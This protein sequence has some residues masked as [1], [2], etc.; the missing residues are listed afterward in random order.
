M[1]GRRLLDAARLFSA[2]SSIVKQHFA[3]RS[4]QW[5]VYTRTSTLAR[6]VKD[7]TDRVTV[8]ARAAYA[9]ARRVNEKPPSY[10]SSSTA[11]Y[12]TQ[13]RYE[14]ESIPGQENVAVGERGKQ[15]YEQGLN[16]DHHYKRS[17]ENAAVEDPPNQ[18]LKVRQEP[19][20]RNALP[21]GTIP[22][23][24]AKLEGASGSQ[25][26]DTFNRRPVSEPAQE[27]LVERSDLG[28]TQKKA[29][30]SPLPDGTIPP[31][32]ARFDKDPA[33]G[34]GEVYSDRPVPETAA[35]PLATN[36]EKTGD[37]LQPVESGESSIP[38][39]RS[40]KD[41][42]K[43]QRLSEFQIPSQSGSEEKSPTAGQDTF[44]DRPCA[45]S[46]D[47]SSLPRMKIPKSEADI[48]GGDEHVQDGQLNQDVYYSS[49]RQPRQPPIPAT[50]AVLEQDEMAEGINT[51]VF[52][53]PRVAS[54]INSGGKEDRRKAYE[55]RMNAARK[56]PIDR[57]PLAQG[58]DQETFNV[59]EDS[60]TVSESTQSSV[61]DASN[62]AKSTNVGQDTL[63]VAESKASD[64]DQNTREF[65]E[66]LAQDV[67]SGQAPIPDVRNASKG[68]AVAELVDNVC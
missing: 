2:S 34:T 46:P 45:S 44:S 58:M 47:L 6:A 9:L 64:I 25:T 53:S 23:A 21:D 61:P 19:A 50:E 56:T 38:T 68:N 4:Q 32:G 29:A 7:Q 12:Q 31:K 18:D 39:P 48:Q 65:A 36:Q 10:T 51:D 55:M 63:K 49:Q 14:E 3:I 60:E 24:G 22:P 40:S 35:D 30:R 8:T 17:E 66:S 62:K 43:M 15:G 52:H 37:D 11:N 59:R 33:P 27:P 54:L 42:M 41:T 57:S 26:Q 13:A 5:D 1:A 67:T 28:V 16:Q 20:A